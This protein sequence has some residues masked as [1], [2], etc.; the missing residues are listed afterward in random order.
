MGALVVQSLA[1]GALAIVTTP[2]A[3][4]A[5]VVVAGLLSGFVNVRFT[6]LLQLAIAPEMRGRVFAVLRTVTDALVP[7]A[8]VLAGVTADLIG[9]NVPLVYGAC[10]AALTCVS[11]A[12]AGQ[13]ACRAFLAGPARAAVPAVAAPPKQPVTVGAGG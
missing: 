10:G 12:I 1:L 11:L 6:T 3:A 5:L 2:R 4:L 13:P 7:V 9:R 8:A